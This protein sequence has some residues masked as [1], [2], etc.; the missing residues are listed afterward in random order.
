MPNQG[1]PKRK[2]LGAFYTAEEVVDFLVRWG[3][4]RA[5]GTVFDPA[6]GD[7]RFLASA[8]AH[9]A[10]RVVGCDVDPA[11]IAA[12]RKRLRGELRRSELVT[13]SF[14]EQEPAEGP[15]VDLVVGNPPFIRYQ[16]FTG[17]TRSLALAS[18]LRIGVRLTRLTSAWA[19]FLLHAVRFLRRGGAMAMVVPAEIVQSQYGIETL[20]ALCGRF[21]AVELV[22]FARNFFDE[23]QTE[24]YLLLAAGHGGRAQAVTLRPLDTV[25]ELLSLDTLERARGTSVPVADE[26]RIRFAEALLRPRE[27][28]VWQHCVGLA[29]VRRLGQLGAVSNGYVTG[30]NRFFHRTRAEALRLGIPP[31]WLRPAVPN[32]KSLRG[33]TF[34][35]AD[36]E[37]LEAGGT[38]QHL[39]CL[40]ADDLFT[41]AGRDAL[42]VLVDEGERHGLHRRFKCRTRKP[43]WRVPGLSVPD[44]LVPYMIGTAPVS[45]VN[46]VDAIYSN[47]MHGVR[48][49]P[50]VS[51]RAVAVGL[52]STVAL[53]GMELEG[54]SYGGGV[55]KLEPSELAAVPVAVPRHDI[56]R[57][58]R[59]DA[60]LRDGDYAGAVALADR[61]VVASGLGVDDHMLATLRGARQ[62]LLERR[63][64][65]SQKRSGGHDAFATATAAGA[66]AP[67]ARAGRSEGSSPRRT[68]RLP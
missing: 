63:V 64:R 31:D 1:V 34:T 27:R 38:P 14:F 48:L 58:R 50:R 25:A 51:V 17:R 7:G 33:L 22:L 10:D 52:H 42:R 62:R 6:C 5:S 36:V 55:L 18:A 24:T 37:G 12:T 59:I 66:A 32:S 19:P 30:A 13:G 4:G 20:R 15:P 35:A 26:G 3:L 57:F 54:R 39:L 45:S 28:A 40:P 67:P 65:R 29:S 49:R 2:A 44:L 61:A 23:A 47:T 16:R 9:G 11:A 46:E 53:L 41:G 56:R 60:L 8:L 68:A 43:W 21:A